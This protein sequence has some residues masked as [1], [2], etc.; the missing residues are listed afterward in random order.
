MNTDNRISNEVEFDYGPFFD[1]LEKKDMTPYQLSVK[2]DIPYSI[3]IRMKE[4]GN[5]SLVT[6][7]KL[8]KKTG[9]HDLNDMVKI[10]IN[11]HDN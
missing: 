3:F 5:L 7:V 6:T 11:N 10:M 4:G 2:E 9:I 8:M 1:L